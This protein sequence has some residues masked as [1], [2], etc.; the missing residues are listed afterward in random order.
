MNNCVLFSIPGNELMCHSLTELL[1]VEPGEAI[2]RHFP[3]G[4]PM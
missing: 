3:D 2:I 4:E 1:H